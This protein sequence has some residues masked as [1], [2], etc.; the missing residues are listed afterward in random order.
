MNNTKLITAK[1][2]MHIL[3]CSRSRVSQLCKAGVLVVKENG[4][5]LESVN[6]YKTERKPAGRPLG[7]YKK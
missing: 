1:E 7:S 6:R 3:S 2:A 5:T 4:I